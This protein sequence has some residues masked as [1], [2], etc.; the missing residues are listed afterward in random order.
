M[1]KI[2]WNGYLFSQPDSSF[3]FA[4]LQYDL[5]ES[6]NNKKKMAKALNTQGVS[7]GIRGDYAKA[8]DY[9]TRGLKLQEEIG[10]KKGIANSLNNI[11]SI[12]HEQGDYTIAI[13][14]YTKSLKIDEEIRNKKGIA[15]SLNNIG[16]IFIVGR[17][18][19]PK[20]WN[21]ILKA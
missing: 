15:S 6:V 16:K 19:L 20:P 12:Y 17:A 3:Y 14:Y 8:I 18:T 13:E 9:Q 2:A 5:A 10:N 21:I 11:G 7:F 4:Q 1:H